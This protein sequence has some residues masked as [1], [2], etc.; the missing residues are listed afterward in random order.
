MGYQKEKAPAVT[1]ANE[2]E[3]KSMFDNHNNTAL[4]EI[5]EHEGNQVVSGRALHEFLQIETPYTKWFDR[6]TEYGFIQ[7][8]DFMTKMSEST[9]G[10][11]STDHLLSIDMGKEI[12][13][14]Q[15]T[16]LGRRIRQYF[17]E[18]EKR[19]R[20]Q[21]APALP[22]VRDL[23]LMVIEAEDARE[24]AEQKVAELEPRARV[25]DAFE[26]SNG[27]TI[28]AFVRKYFPDEKESRIFDFLY[29]VKKFLIHDPRGKWSVHQQKYVPGPNHMMPRVNGREFFHTPEEIDRNGKA[30]LSTRVRRD[31]EHH[32]VSYL[33]RHGFRPIGD[34]LPSFEIEEVA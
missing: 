21:V 17:I 23:A 33:A 26:Q 18:V 20:A 6:M 31:R 16:E 24:A 8:H 25:A 3:S 15:R 19:A 30:R 34:A 1:G 27:L 2:T 14:I 12:G 10:R 9:G 13:M 7:G 32:L 4:V 22:S 5:R 29:H 28:R 11:P